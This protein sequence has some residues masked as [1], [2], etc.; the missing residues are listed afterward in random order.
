M[1]HYEF[2][3]LSHL[4]FTTDE[5]IDFFVI[6]SNVVTFWSNDELS[7]IHQ[8]HFVAH[9]SIGFSP[10]DH[11]TM[12]IDQIFHI[13]FSLKSENPTCRSQHQTHNHP[14]CNSITGQ[15]QVFFV[16]D[17]FSCIC[18]SIKIN[19]ITLFFPSFRFHVPDQYQNLIFI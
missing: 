13:F 14:D 16:T 3:I 18:D 1:F 12:V 11:P 17:H 2:T 4:Y 6:E 8:R 7:I 5:M 10:C 9:L 15:M 19:L